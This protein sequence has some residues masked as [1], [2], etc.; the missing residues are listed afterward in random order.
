MVRTAFLALLL[1]TGCGEKVEPQPKAGDVHQIP[2][3]SWHIVD[4]EE[5]LRVYTNSGMDVAEGHKL[6][7]FV[8]TTED[9]DYVVFTLPPKVVDGQETCTLG[10]EVMHMALGGY[11]Q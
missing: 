2:S 7:G 4:E 3:F 9:G 10:H 5:L 1:L 11:H 6:H 8:G